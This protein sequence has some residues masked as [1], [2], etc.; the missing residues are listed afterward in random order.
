[1]GQWLARVVGLGDLLPQE[2]MKSAL[3]AI[4]WHNFREDLSAHHSVQRVYAVNDEAGLLL[5]TWP[6]GGRPQY[7]FPYADEVWTGIEYYVAAHCIYEGLLD[8]G[9]KIVE[10]VRARHSG[11]NRN[12]WDEYECG[13]HYARAMSSWSLI[14]ALSGYH[15]NAAKGQLA[16]APHINEGDFKCF[17]STGNAWGQFSQTR[18][19]EC[20][21]AK[22]EVRW[23]ELELRELA[24]PVGNVRQVV[25]AGRSIS[26]RSEA[27]VIRFSERVTIRAGQALEV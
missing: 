21:S 24:L 15:Y 19:G 7:P 6:N 22:V 2:K 9:L 25:V 5:C 26:A 20:Y 10:A 12:P 14:T 3:A 13:H 17:F 8:E 23:G 11:H 18:E 1:L 16:F 27:G 4:V